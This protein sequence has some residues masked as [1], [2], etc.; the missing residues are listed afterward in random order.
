MYPQGGREGGSSENSHED[1]G[2]R[3]C[4]Q[5][6]LKKKLWGREGQRLKESPFF[7]HTLQFLIIVFQI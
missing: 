7:S 2:G 6:T 5:N 4:I 3:E 1:E